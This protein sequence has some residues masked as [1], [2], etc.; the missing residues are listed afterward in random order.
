ME[1]ARRRGQAAETVDVRAYNRSAWN[2]QVEQGN[3]WTVPVSAERVERARQ[4]EWEIVL[5]PTKAV[6]RAWFGDLAGARVLCL[7]SGGGQQ[8]PLLAAAGADV[9]VFDN[10]PAQ[11]AQDRMVAAR[12]GLAIECIEGD[13]ADPAALADES[14]D[15]VVH[16]VSNCFVPDVRPVWRAAHRVLRPGGALLAGF[17][18]P[19]LYLFDEDLSDT[20][21]LIARHRIPYSDLKALSA[22]ELEARQSAGEP[23]NFGHSLDD[24]IGGQLDAG[25]VIVGFYED[26]WRPEDD[27]PIARLLPC[28]AATRAVRPAAAAGK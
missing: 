25:L 5:T 12:E 8:G 7:A 26:H 13:M 27:E 16:P 22:A 14:F 11:L 24:Q 9:T 21:E 28:F 10:S 15:L 17:C 4:G 18:N 2:R 23:L 6:P 20:G 19:V 3:P 1:S